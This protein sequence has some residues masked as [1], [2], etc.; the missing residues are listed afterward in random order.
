LYVLSLIIAF[1]ITAC[2]GPNCP[3]PKGFRSHRR[4]SPTQVMHQDHP[5]ASVPTRS[6]VRRAAPAVRQQP[7]APSEQAP[8]APAEKAAKKS[9]DSDDDFP[10]P[11]PS[12]DFDGH[13]FKKSASV[14]LSPDESRMLAGINRLRAANGK[15]PVSSDPLLMK[16]A[17]ERVNT[18]SS[19]GHYS[20][21]YGRAQQHAAR[22]ANWS[23]V[24]DVSS[25]SHWSDGSRETPEQACD[26]WRQSYGHL[27]CVLGRHNINNRWVDEG[28]DRVGVAMGHRF[29]TAVFGRRRENEAKRGSTCN[30]RQGGPC[31]C[32]AGAC[33]CKGCKNNQ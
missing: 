21:Q 27:Q 13:N 17:R 6:L 8:A 14:D 19:N 18:L 4:H 33:K 10:T 29:D 30:C 5:K 11:G 15:P 1:V 20:P 32:P 31:T 25:E 24:N 3:G 16:V 26:G 2:T 12:K 7:S 28:Y 23:D 22:Y 9:A